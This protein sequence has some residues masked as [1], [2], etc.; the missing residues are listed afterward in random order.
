MSYLF[1]FWA[2][3]QI[4]WPVADQAPATWPATDLHW[5]ASSAHPLATRLLKAAK[6]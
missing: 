5:L 4:A 2:E 6:R 3:Q 1:V